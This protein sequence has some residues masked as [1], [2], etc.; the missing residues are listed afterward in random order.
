MVVKTYQLDKWTGVFGRRYTERNTFTTDQLNGLYKREYGVTRISMNRD[1]LDGMDRSIRILEVGSNVGNQL[2][3]L[4]RMGFRNLY[5]IEPQW[6]AV[7]ALRKFTK[8]INVITGSVFDIPFKDGY[9]DIVFTSGVL[10]HISP[11]DIGKAV[12]EI[13][14]CSKKYIWG[15]EYYS[16]SYEQI[17]Y[18]GEKRLLWK[19]DFP[20]IYRRIYPNLKASKIKFFKYLKN[21]NI[22]QM[23]LLKK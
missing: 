15:F 14:R 9:F 5:G 6:Y 13:V 3:L 7:N 19:A 22:D 10:I 16:K 20:G 21:D 4:Q 23:F 1:F 11:E 18:R 17:V 8:N 12:K 2:N